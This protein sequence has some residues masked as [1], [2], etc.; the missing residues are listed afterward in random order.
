MTAP[1]FSSFRVILTGW[2]LA[3]RRTLTGM[4]VAAGVVGTRHHA[5]YHRVFSAAPWSIDRLGLAVFDLIE[6]W[7]GLPATIWLSLDDSH[8]R[9]RGTKIFGAGMHHDPLISTR[10][11]HVSTWGLNWVVLCV[12]VRLSCC[13]DRV[14]SLPILFRLYLNQKAARRWGRVYRSK[15]ALAVELLQRLCRSRSERRFHAVVDNSYGGQSVLTQLPPNCDLTSRLDLDARLY[16]AP[17]QRRPSK[18]GTRLPTPRQMLTQRGRRVTLDL[19]GRRDRV[20]LVECTARCH[21]LPSRALRVVVVDPL[22]GGRPVQAFFTTVACAPGVQV[23]RWYARRWSIEETFFGSKTLLGMH[24]PQVWSRPAVQRTA[25]VGMLLY[26]LVVVWFAQEG[27]ARWQPQATSWYRARRAPSFGD[28]L[29]T[30]RREILRHNLTSATPANDPQTS[31]VHQTMVDLI[32]RA[33]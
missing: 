32:A 26:S 8:S 24:Q 3:R 33:A 7:V 31:K 28:M 18:R 9:K 15:P 5:T 4:L 20:R 22:A 29:A 10:A 12:V 27:I 13:P 16:T 6:Q 19:Y 21:H 14:F 30:L 1:T 2:L 23:L 17:H 11:R 25:P